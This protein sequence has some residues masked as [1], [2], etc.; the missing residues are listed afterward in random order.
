MKKRTREFN[1]IRNFSVGLINQILML[2]LGL[3][4]KNIF[5]KALGTTYMGLNGL[6]SNIFLALSFAEFGI[7][8]VMVYTLY[9]P[10]AFDNEPG[11]SAL[12]YFFRKLYKRLSLIITLVSLAVIPLLPLIV[13]IDKSAGITGIKTFYVL[14]LMGVVISNNYMYKSHMI[15]ADQKNYILSLYNMIFDNGTTIIQIILLL[16]TKNYYLYLIAFIAKSI[17]FSLATSYKVKKL[18]PYLKDNKTMEQIGDKE[19]S[20]IYTKIKDVFSYKFAKAFINVSDIVLISMLVGTIWV[21]YYSNYNL[22]ILGVTGLIVTFYDGISASVGD[23]IATKN[24]KDQYGIFETIQ[25]L[26]IW[27]VGF[28]TTSLFIL[29]QDFISIWLGKEYVIDFKIVILIIINYALVCNRKAITIFREAAGVFNKIKY[30]V[31]W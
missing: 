16:K 13:N 7:G 22:I 20:D 11:I 10:L 1:S 4:A 29:F 25:I 27:I 26:N 24:I 14:Y 5:L 8:S 28:T 12:Y 17:I 19:K 21:G 6:F 9:T 23:F 30:A 15:L 2:L 3:V 31:F 18:Y